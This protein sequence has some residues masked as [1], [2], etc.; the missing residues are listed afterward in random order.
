MERQ[1]AP[2]IVFGNLF[3]VSTVNTASDSEPIPR[4]ADV[5]IGQE[6]PIVCTG[7]PAV[8]PFAL[9]ALALGLLGVGMLMVWRRARS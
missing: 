1:P 9:I 4:F 7:A 2:I 6:V 8:S 5:S 3:P